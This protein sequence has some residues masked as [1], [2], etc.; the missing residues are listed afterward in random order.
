MII[1]EYKPE[2]FSNWT[3]YYQHKAKVAKI[4]QFGEYFLLVLILGVIAV[5]SIVCLM[6]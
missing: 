3:A 1:R 6:F 2:G 5:D 4:K